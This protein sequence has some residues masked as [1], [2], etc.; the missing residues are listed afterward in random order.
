MRCKPMKIRRQRA[1]ELMACALREPQSRHRVA[2]SWVSAVSPMSS[3]GSC[4]LSYDR[5]WVMAG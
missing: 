1:G 5:K 4:G 3:I 2:D